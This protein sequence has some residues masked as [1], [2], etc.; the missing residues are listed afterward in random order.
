MGPNFS[1][2]QETPKA[3]PESTVGLQAE[4]NRIKQ[5]IRV[6]DVTSPAK[7]ASP[8]KY[9]DADAKAAKAAAET[10]AVAEAT[11]LREEFAALK[12]AY[13]REQ[14]VSKQFKDVV[15]EYETTLRVLVEGHAN[16]L[17]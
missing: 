5:K 15:D 12:A 7:T 14:A 16:E 9:M 2:L 3:L 13:E 10:S 6:W 8:S 4:L 11:K 1:S 17:E